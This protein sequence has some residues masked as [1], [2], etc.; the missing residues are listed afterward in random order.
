MIPPYLRKFDAAT[1]SAWLASGN[2]IAL[3]SIFESGLSGV[4]TQRLSAA[5]SQGGSREFARIAGA[6]IFF[7][8]VMSTVVSV[9]KSVMSPFMVSRVHTPR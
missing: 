3:I 6:G 9:L 4:I 2:L 7:A 5:Y 8:S 1:Y